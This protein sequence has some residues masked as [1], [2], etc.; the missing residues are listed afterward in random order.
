M[1]K[2]PIIRVGEEPPS[3]HVARPSTANNPKGSAKRAATAR[4]RTLN[5]FVDST[6]S[7]LSRAEMAVWLTLFRDTRDG[8]ARTSMSDLARRAGCS[9]RAVVT[10]VAALKKRGL[11]K[12]LRK[13]GL[14]RGSSCYAVRPLAKND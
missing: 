4:F 2:P 5:A 3:L 11:L 9:R 14:N 12:T 8:S 1:S 10:A 7:D 13:G 6:M